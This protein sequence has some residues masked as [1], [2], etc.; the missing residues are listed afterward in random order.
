[1]PSASKQFHVSL[2]APSGKLQDVLMR[3]KRTGVHL[4]L[5]LGEGRLQ[6]L[7]TFPF[8]VIK[9]WLP[10]NLRS[11]NVGPDNCLDLEIETDRGPRDLRMRTE[12]AASVKTII[13]ALRDTVQAVLQD[14]E[15]R[16]PPPPTADQ[17]AATDIPQPLPPITEEKETLTVQD[18][19][20]STSPI[21]RNA[22]FTQTMPEPPPPVPGPSRHEVSSLQA[23]MA[24]LTEQNAFLENLVKRLSAEVARLQPPNSQPPTYP[25]MEVDDGTPLPPWLKDRRYL[26]PLLTSYDNRLAQTEAKANEATSALEQLQ[27]QLDEVVAE[28]DKLQDRLVQMSSQ[29]ASMA[30]REPHPATSSAHA[31]LKEENALLRQENDLL[32]SQ[33]GEADRELQRLH[34]QLEEHKQTAVRMAQEEGTAQMRS[35]QQAAQLQVMAAQYSK[36]QASMRAEA[37]RVAQL[38]FQLAEARSQLE[39][40]HITTEAA[41]RSHDILT[42]E[43]GSMRDRAVAADTRARVATEKLA[44]LQMDNSNL[45]ERL[46]AATSEATSSHKDCE[47]LRQALSTVE[48]KLSVYQQKDAEVYTRIREALEAA[49]GARLARDASAAQKKELEAELTAMQQRMGGVRQAVRDQVYAELQDRIHALTKERDASREATTAADSEANKAHAAA[50]LA[51]RETLSLQSELKALKEQ[52]GETLSTKSRLSLLSID[53]MER[54]QAVERERDEAV[55]QMEKEARRV[56][57]TKKEWALEKQHLELEL[58]TLRRTV[59]ELEAALTTARGEAAGYARQCEALGRELVAARQAKERIETDLRQQIANVRAERDAEIRGMAARLEATVASAGRS[60]GEAEQHMASQEALMARWRE[61]A[62]MVASKLDS[63]LASHRRELTARET[64]MSVLSVDLQGAR[65]S[66]AAAA[67][68]LETLQATAARM[69]HALLEAESNNKQLRLQLLS[70]TARQEDLESEL[71]TLHATLEHL[72]SSQQSKAP[73]GLVGND[74]TSYGL[75]QRLDQLRRGS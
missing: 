47:A 55:G 61:E 6:E 36:L 56:E 22:A 46:E 8:E 10:S 48:A 50:D 31:L 1:M 33:Q 34:Q 5:E 9:K 62:Q 3:I 17:E 18:R 41:K 74:A 26:N 14:L 25:L 35:Q 40:E 45:R 75:A 38:E 2:V 63:A 64:E 7:N 24:E 16:P 67:A 13:Q 69:Q 4:H 59:P 60:V 51:A 23:H 57:R 30:G 12:S 21:F 71:R 52:M 68:E 70:A 15:P 73:Q 27:K 58:R 54:I 28:N 43:Q 19:E 20:A 53:T 32:T 42:M 72:R 11:R 44:A 37:Q 29:A 65:A 49:E 39:D 66:H